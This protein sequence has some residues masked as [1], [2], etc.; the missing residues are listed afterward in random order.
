MGAINIGSRGGGNVKVSAPDGAKA[1]TEVTLPK[2]N[3]TLATLEDISSLT[4]LDVDALIEVVD[5]VEENKQD[6]IELEEEIDALAPTF[7]RGHW[8]YKAPANPT[9]SPEEATYFILDEDG[10]VATEFSKTAEILFHNDD[11]A[12]TTHTWAGIEEGQFIEVFDS[13]D[14][15]FLLAEIDEVSLEVGYVKFAVTVKQSEGGPSGM[16]P[17]PASEHRVRIKIFEIP[18]VDITTLMPKAGGTFTGKVTHTKDI[19]SKPAGTTTF[20]NLKTFPPKHPETGEW[21][22]SSQFGFNVDLDMGNSGYNAFKFSNR[23]GSILTMNGGSNPAAKYEGRITEKNHLVNK[24]Y[25]DARIVELDT[26][27]SGGNT[28]KFNSSSNAP[29]DG[30]FT[31]VS[32][33]TSS[34]KE[35]HIKKLWDSAGNAIQ[36]KDYKATP[37]SMFELYEGTKLLV[38]TAIK[39]W[40]TS[41]RGST[42]MMFNCAGYKPT[43]YDAVYLDTAK[44]YSIFLTNM[45]KK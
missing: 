7:D 28:F 23:N 13:N 30:Y 32:S 38:K 33:L 12:E 40:K 31:T 15:E 44:V 8:D 9:D 22:Y 6:I 14:E 17:D 35:W 37:G 26:L 24:E 42:A 1:G 11:V 43:V 5:Q 27:H 25:V 39:D 21:D 20:V 41:T 16:P 19:E 45:K 10:T 4:D 36:C 2:H 3:G 18:E 29:N 34:N